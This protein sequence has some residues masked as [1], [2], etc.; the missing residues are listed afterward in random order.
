MKLL[1]C[2]RCGDIFS[3]NYKYKQCSCGKTS[4]FYVTQENMVYSGKYANVLS[5]ENDSIHEGLENIPLD[6]R[7]FEIEAHVVP[8]YC[9][10]A[11]KVKDS[12][13]YFNQHMLQYYKYLTPMWQYNVAKVR[14]TNPFLKLIYKMFKRYIFFTFAE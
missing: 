2:S 7:G 10:S 1:N 14:I 9:D 13:K 8:Y 11:V 3:L 5:I 6:G 12:Y 4:G